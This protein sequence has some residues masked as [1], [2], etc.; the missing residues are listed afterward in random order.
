MLDGGEYLLK[1]KVNRFVDFNIGMQTYVKL[2][3]DTE[4]LFSPEGLSFKSVKK[5]FDK[6]SLDA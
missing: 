5:Q 1:S 3:S 4:D 2:N 6:F